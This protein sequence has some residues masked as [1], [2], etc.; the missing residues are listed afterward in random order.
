MK[1]ESDIHELNPGKGANKATFAR[2]TKQ[3]Y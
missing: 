1:L 2:V 3:P